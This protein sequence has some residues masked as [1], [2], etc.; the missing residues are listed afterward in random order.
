MSYTYNIEEFLSFSKIKQIE[1]F[2]QP[3]DVIKAYLS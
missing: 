1:L 2:L 3:S